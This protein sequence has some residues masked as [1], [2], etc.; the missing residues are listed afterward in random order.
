MTLGASAAQLTGTSKPIAACAQLV[1][2]AG[3]K[4][5]AG[6]RLAENQH[7]AVGARDLLDRLAHRPHRRPIAGQRPQIAAGP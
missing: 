6:A 5:L 7:R 2:G 3:D 4:F 1:D